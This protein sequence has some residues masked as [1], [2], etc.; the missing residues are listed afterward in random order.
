MQ[1]CTGIGKYGA[2][3]RHAEVV[4]LTLTECPTCEA[5]KAQFNA[6]EKL[7]DANKK[8]QELDLEIETLRRQLANR[9]SEVNV[10]EL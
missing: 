1:V 3:T 5:L 9:E 2:S 8:L 10:N 7:F 6:E 4:H